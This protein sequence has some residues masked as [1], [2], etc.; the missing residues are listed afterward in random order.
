MSAVLAV[1]IATSAV[2]ERERLADHH[3]GHF[4]A[5]A[6]A[7]VSLRKRRV[8]NCMVFLSIARDG[9]RRVS[10]A[11][12]RNGSGGWPP[13]RSQARRVL[14]EPPRARRRN[15]TGSALAEAAC[16]RP[17]RR[18]VRAAA[19]ARPSVRRRRRQFARGDAAP[20]SGAR[21][22]QPRRRPRRDGALTTAGGSTA[23]AAAAPDEE[24]REHEQHA[25]HALQRS[26]APA[27]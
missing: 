2:L 24:Q 4:G 8:A 13:S 16:A 3:L 25:D 12:G 6:R 14:G 26:A 9:L 11:K 15:A 1:T 5:R 21:A 20:S 22:R 19:V 18:G 23:S 10:E 7:S 17:W 27:P